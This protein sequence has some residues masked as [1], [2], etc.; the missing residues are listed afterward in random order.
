MTENQEP[1]SIGHR[2]NHIM[3]I[4]KRKCSEIQTQ[5]QLKKSQYRLCKNIFTPQTYGMEESRKE[6]KYKPYKKY[7]K[8][9][10]LKRSTR[11]KPYLDPRR[12][13]RKY[14]PKRIYRNK[15]KC[16]ACGEPDHLST[17]CPRK[18]NL[19]N[20]RSML[21]ECT[22]EEL[23]EIDDEI[24]DTETIYSMV[25]ITEGKQNSDSENEDL[26]NDLAELE[27]PN[28]EFMDITCEHKWKKNRGLDSIRCFKCKWF[29]DRLH[30]AKCQK[31][32][33]EGCIICI[34]EYFDTNISTEIN[35]CQ[36]DNQE[37]I[38]TLSIDE[39]IKR[40]EQ[41]IIIIKEGFNDLVTKFEKYIGKKKLEDIP[42][43]FM[44]EENSNVIIHPIE[45]CNKLREI[46]T[47][48]IEGTIRVEDFLIKTYALL[49]TGC[50]HVII[51]EK[52]I[53][54]RFITLAEK[55]MIAQ[56][57]NGSFNRY[58]NHLS[59]TTKISF[60]KN[61]YSSPE[62]SLPLKETWI[63]PLNLGHQVILGLSFLLKDNEK[64]TF[65]KDFF[66]L[67]KTFHDKP[68]KKEIRNYKSRRIR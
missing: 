61:C 29:P 11:R 42:E 62:Y 4:L 8:R 58:T 32:Y 30:R 28:T 26:I 48:Q 12:H 40:I 43:E 56:Q 20:T 33:L 7:N 65:N 5:R 60:M 34:E 1:W 16:Y 19:Y 55:P 15:L 46:K 66:Y 14:N 23:V 3:K 10:F 44:D 31:C 13:V 52:I 37:I 50:T 41:E 54:K 21:L 64:I 57:V 38:N 63:K 68:I 67:I 27:F 59:T 2:I 25:S 22:N 9:Y 18:K 39:K 6:K 47:P 24:S 45:I 36:K 49:D 51:D 53:P 17:N 35:E